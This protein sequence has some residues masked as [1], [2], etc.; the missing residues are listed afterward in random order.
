MSYDPTP[1]DVHALKEQ[2]KEINGRYNPSL[3]K[4]EQ[5]A[6]SPGMI[7][8]LE[9]TVTPKNI[10]PYAR[11]Y[12]RN[13]RGNTELRAESITGTMDIRSGF[14]ETRPL[15]R[16]PYEKT[17]KHI[18]VFETG[19]MCIGTAPTTVLREVFDN[20]IGACIYSRAPSAANYDSPA[21]KDLITWQ[22]AKEGSGEFPLI[23]PKLMFFRPMPAIRTGKNS[24]RTQGGLPGIIRH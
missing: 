24:V 17:L 19:N 10:A 22:K 9:F 21:D 13:R 23:D 18:N 11:V 2:L 1:D 4:I 16:F 20:I 5:I 8:T 3:V 14:P 12:I 7:A 6:A 15:V